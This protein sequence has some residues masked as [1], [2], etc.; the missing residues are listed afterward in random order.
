MFRF[1]F[2][3]RS[4]YHHQAFQFPAKRRKTVLLEMNDDSSWEQDIFCL[5]DIES[6]ETSE[7]GSPDAFQQPTLFSFALDGDEICFVA[8]QKPQTRR[9]S[10]LAVQQDQG[11]DSRVMPPAMVSPTL[12]HSPSM[13][14]LIVP[15]ACITSKF[16]HSK[17]EPT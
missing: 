8:V 6:F 14:H 13:A 10:A 9:T 17:E 1:Q 16:K 3:K 11:Q 5:F 4:P 15:A 7:L 2:P 12:N